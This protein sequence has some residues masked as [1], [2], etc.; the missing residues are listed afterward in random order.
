MAFFPKII[1][2]TG[3]HRIIWTAPETIIVEGNAGTDGLGN[4]SWKKAPQPAIIGVL[5]DYVIGRLKLKYRDELEK[6]GIQVPP[7]KSK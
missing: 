3:A 1:K 6:E 7:K 4:I 2:D 5:T